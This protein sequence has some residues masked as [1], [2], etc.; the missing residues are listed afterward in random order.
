MKTEVKQ[1][2]NFSRPVMCDRKFYYQF[3]MQRGIFLRIAKFL[4]LSVP[5]L[6]R[7]ARADGLMNRPSDG[8]TASF[9]STVSWEERSKKEPSDLVMQWHMCVN[10]LPR[11]ALDSREAGIELA[12]Y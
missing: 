4:G 3:R 11:V 8:Q 7:T 6:T 1:L 10:N 12:T 9:R 2:W 5:D